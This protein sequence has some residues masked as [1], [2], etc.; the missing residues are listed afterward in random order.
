MAEN[1]IFQ[2]Y[3]SESDEIPDKIRECMRNVQHH[4]AQNEY[5]LLHNQMVL[6]FLQMS[7]EP[8]VASAYQKL[9][10]FAYKADLARLCL[11]F[12]Y[13]G[14]YLDSTVTLTGQMPKVDDHINMIVFK[15]APNPK[16]AGSWNVNNGVI[17]SKRGS[18]VI[19]MAIEIIIKNVKTS[20]YGRTSLDPTGPGVLGRALAIN[21]PDTGIM[22][23]WYHP[24]TPWHDMKNFAYILPTGRILALGKSTAGSPDGLGLAA[25]GDSGTNSYEQMYK[26]RNIYN[27]GVV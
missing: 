11:L 22:T 8:A 26:D 2:I 7:F 6:D 1:T 4:K 15:D 25:Y 9:K 13:G 19:K 10:P 16:T 3:I 20:Y 14:W 5:R 23:G 17:Y 18:K 27:D 24:L 21:G 12:K